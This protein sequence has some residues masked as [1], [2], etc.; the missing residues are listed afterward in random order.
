M[1]NR[2]VC[3]VVTDTGMAQ[4]DSANEEC[5]CFEEEPNQQQYESDHNG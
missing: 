4:S 5:I 1:D 2:E 3:G